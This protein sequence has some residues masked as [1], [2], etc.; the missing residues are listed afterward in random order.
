M[1]ELRL[2]SNG[3]VTI[4]IAASSAAEPVMAKVAAFVAPY[5]TPVDG[6]LAQVNF[7]IA[8][9]SFTDL[10][11]VWRERCRQPLTIRISSKTLFDL[12]ALYGETADGVVAAIDERTGTAFVVDRARRHINAYVGEASFVHLIEL[13]RYTA[14]LIE[15]AA[16]TVLLHA[17]AVNTD[18]GTLLMLGEK[19]A[20]KTTTLLHLAFHQGCKLLSG[21]KVLL[22]ERVG[23]LWVRGWPDYPHV[24][25]GTLRGLPGL[26]DRLGVDD[27]GTDDL[28]KAD[29]YKELI[30][31]RR[32]REVVPHAA[33]GQAR[34]VIGIIFP[35]V[36]A[37]ERKVEAVP[38]AEVCIESLAEFV[39]Y[40]HQFTPGHWHGMYRGIAR[41]EPAYDTV[42]LEHLVSV[43]WLR[44]HGGALVDWKE[45]V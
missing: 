42:V 1:A 33:D 7:T 34:N 24:G 15:E 28:R 37:T 19:H 32:Y 43:P 20:G 21:D 3:L 40:P 38:A 6:D 5:F 17:S 16:G 22:R 4:G 44:C 41:T 27:N 18:N 39:E 9:A 8:A 29:S 30:D 12:A 26:S 31:P 45:I 36:S 25:M 35:K 10:P 2:L 23:E 14:L 11:A 13:I